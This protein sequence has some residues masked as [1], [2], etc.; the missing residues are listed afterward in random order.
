MLYAA[1]RNTLTKS[2]GSSNFA[3]SLF[4]TA[5]ADLTA[6]A[7]KK[8]RQ[9]LAAPQPMSAREKEMEEVKAA[10]R[11]S[12]GMA[13]SGSELARVAQSHV[14]LKW[15]EDVE[16]A[17]REL[18]AG[19]GSSVVV[20]TVDSAT[21]TLLLSSVAKCTISDLPNVVPSSEPCFA[22]FAW[23]R[24]VTS[25]RREI[26]YIYS[27]PSSS[28]IKYRMLYSSSFLST[29]MA[30]QQLIPASD[31]SVLSARKI[32]VSD[33]HELTES[34]ISSELGLTDPSP[35]SGTPVVE[36][37]KKPFAKPRGPARKR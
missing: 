12:S 33:P 26:V 21:E 4:A 19:D 5:K 10:E 13:R 1:T 6:D 18:G 31:T 7:Y 3:D 22:F 2:L 30:A 16:N 24:A 8:H 29:Y 17:I 15:T 23:S 37:E 35:A 11:Q 14:G 20:L 32:Q 25:A 34:Y 28:P 9:H 36:A 27:C